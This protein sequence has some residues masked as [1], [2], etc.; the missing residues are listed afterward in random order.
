M[1]AVLLKLV[2]VKDPIDDSV[3]MIECLLDSVAF[4]RFHYFQLTSEFFELV[5]IIMNTSSDAQQLVYTK[6]TQKH[7]AINTTSTGL[8]TS[9]SPSTRYKGLRNL[10]ATCY[11]NSALQALFRVPEFRQS[12]LASESTPDSW[13]FLFQ[14]LYAK[15]L[16]FPAAAIDTRFFFEKWTNSD[17]AKTNVRD[18]QDSFEFL[19]LLLDRIGDINPDA[20]SVFK[21]RLQHETVGVSVE[22]KSVSDEQF[23]ALCL[24][25]SEQNSVD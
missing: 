19:Q 15:L 13:F 20:V 17:G 18:Q 22:Y 3:N 10:G 16:L 23:T 11:A 6:L 7:N 9:F 21:G 8:L 25:I 5:K 4:N 1:I 2:R 12:V 24:D 14:L